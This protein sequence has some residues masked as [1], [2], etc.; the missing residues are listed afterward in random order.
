MTQF[1]LTPDQQ[2]ELRAGGMGLTSG[3][4]LGRQQAG[5][6]RKG[7]Q[8]NHTIHHFGETNDLATKAKARCRQK[9]HTRK[10]AGGVACGEC[11]ESVIRAD[12]R[13]HAQAVNA[14][15]D[16]CVT[17]GHQLTGATA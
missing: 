9:K 4:Q 7:A 17:C 8:G 14:L 1:D 2:D 12:E 5:K 11:W 6:V 15:R 13:Q 10:V 3:A 16:D